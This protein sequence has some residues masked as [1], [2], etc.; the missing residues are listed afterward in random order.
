MTNGSKG[1]YILFSPEKN[2][3]CDRFSS[4][5]LRGKRLWS[6]CQATDDTEGSALAQ[7]SAVRHERRS[8]GG[9]LRSQNTDTNK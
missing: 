2:V 9:D 1:F 4:F 3:V 7:N 6:Y 5:S 8:S